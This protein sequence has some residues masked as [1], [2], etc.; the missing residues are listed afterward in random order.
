MIIELAVLG[1]AG[2]LLALSFRLTEIFAASAALAIFW[3]GLA[4]GGQ[5]STGDAIIHLVANLGA[6]QT[7]A[8]AILLIRLKI[9]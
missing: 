6:F 9:S 2:A 7:G 4:F 3:L 1:I 5:V 8:A